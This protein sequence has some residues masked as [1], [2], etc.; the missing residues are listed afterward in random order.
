MKGQ[1]DD[2]NVWIRDANSGMNEV[3]SSKSCQSSL[4]VDKM[5]AIIKDSG[6]WSCYKLEDYKD[7]KMSFVTARVLRTAVS[8][9]SS[10]NESTAL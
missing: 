5:S 7:V 8:S 10:V 4:P 6:K 9:S 1:E 2:A 3:I